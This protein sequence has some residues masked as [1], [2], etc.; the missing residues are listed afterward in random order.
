MW[1][2]AANLVSLALLAGQSAAPV[3]VGLPHVIP[4]PRLQN[5]SAEDLQAW[6]RIRRSVAV[7]ELNGRPVATAV[8][9]DPAG[10]FMTHLSAAGANQMVG[11]LSTGTSFNLF[12]V[13]VDETTQLALFETSRSFVGVPPVKTSTRLPLAGEHVFAV[14]ADGVH[15]GEYVGGDRVGILRPSLRY[16]PLVEVKLETP[17]GRVGGAFVFDRS[18]SLVGVL[19]ATLEVVDSQGVPGGVGRPPA[20][21]VSQRAARALSG[22]FGP[23]GLTVGYAL[24]P[25]VIKRAIDGFLS[26]DRQVRHPSIGVFFRQ[27]TGG[28][29]GALLEDVLPSG[30]AWL[31]GLRAG[32]LIVEVDGR[33]IDGPIALAVAIFG[34]NPGDEMAVHAM[35][36]GNLHQFVIAVGTQDD[37]TRKSETDQRN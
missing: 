28:R 16:A 18:G 22:T 12:L 10:L 8:L 36:A 25:Q 24:G 19:N 34:K 3:R 37:N 11:R 29:P 15:R 20:I 33:P 14:T 21:G 6:T 7:L 2:S 13:S 9:V 5:W 32:D 1:C 30:P 23:A 4:G 17:E 27:P 31:A 26:Y 35:R